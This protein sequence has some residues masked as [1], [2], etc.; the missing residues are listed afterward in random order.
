ME[1]NRIPIKESQWRSYVS[2]FLHGNRNSFATPSRGNP[3]ISRIA[4][5]DD[6]VA[7]DTGLYPADSLTF[8]DD[9]GNGYES[10]Q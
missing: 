9:S 10:R 2:K 7:Y 1:T 5:T 4:V 3:T 6:G 8:A